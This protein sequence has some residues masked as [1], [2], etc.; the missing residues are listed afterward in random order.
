MDT[1]TKL[2]M[3]EGPLTPA[4]EG[5]FPS[6][7]PCHQGLRKVEMKTS[8]LEVDFS[9]VIVFVLFLIK[10]LVLLPFHAAFGV[11][12]AIHSGEGECEW[13]REG[14]PFHLFSI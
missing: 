12:P 1:K 9:Y 6:R 8:L 14:F 4:G 2:Q 10:R 3:A 5:G 11:L 13:M 7:P